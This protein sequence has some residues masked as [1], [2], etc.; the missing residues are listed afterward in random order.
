MV[1]GLIQ[2]PTTVQ[3]SFMALKKGINPEYKY[4]M[5]T[6]YLVPKGTRLLIGKIANFCHLYIIF[7]NFSNI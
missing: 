4:F 2:D 1:R 7:E 6:T 5:Q 3:E